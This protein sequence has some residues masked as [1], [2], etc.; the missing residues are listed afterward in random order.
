MYFARPTIAIAKIRDYSQSITKEDE[1]RHLDRM[2]FYYNKKFL[3][4]KLFFLKFFDVTLAKSREYYKLLIQ[5][6]ATLPKSASKLQDKYYCIS[7]PK[8]YLLS[9]TVCLETY[10]R[11]FQF[12]ILNYITCTNILLKKMGKV[13]SDLCSFCNTDREYI[14][15]LF[16]HC[17]FPLLLP[18]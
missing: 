8:I 5:L 15:H 17:P 10:L 18:G 3:F 16:Y 11:D 12:K 13:D 9:R 4:F 2:G 6:K 7:L 14:E 1:V